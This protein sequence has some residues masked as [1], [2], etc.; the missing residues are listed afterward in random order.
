MLNSSSVLCSSSTY[1]VHSVYNVVAYLVP[2]VN[3][4]V[5]YQYSTQC[6]QY[7][8]RVLTSSSVL[9]SSSTYT[10]NSVYSI[11]VHLV[12]L[13]YSVVLVPIRYTVYVI[14]GVL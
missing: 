3:F 12:T 11:V 7:N 1:T 9:C 13:M 10:V 8:S 5:Q 14:S 2:Q 4:L 6:I